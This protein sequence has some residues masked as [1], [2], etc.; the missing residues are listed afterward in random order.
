VL[1]FY[2]ILC[3]LACACPWCGLRWSRSNST[4]LYAADSLAIHRRFIVFCFIRVVLH[5]MRGAKALKP[6]T[7]P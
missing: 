7:T 6:K 4:P 2:W 5:T 3:H 1:G